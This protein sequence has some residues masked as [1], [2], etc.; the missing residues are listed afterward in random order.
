MIK[1][2]LCETAID[3]EYPP[4]GGK[5]PVIDAYDGCQL[6]CPYCFQW[7]TMRPTCPGHTK[8][9]KLNLDKASSFKHIPL[10]IKRIISVSANITK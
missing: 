3:Y 1:E 5:V 2:I 6:C 9:P 4:D 10:F 7:E 8:W